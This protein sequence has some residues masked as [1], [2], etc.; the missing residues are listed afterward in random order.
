MAQMDDF[1]QFSQGFWLT[2]MSDRLKDGKVTGKDLRWDRSLPVS[3]FDW[4]TQVLDFFFPQEYV[5]HFLDGLY[6]YV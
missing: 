2:N 5:Y 1:N 6:I 4:K 3:L